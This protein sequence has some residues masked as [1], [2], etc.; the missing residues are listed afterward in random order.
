MN[1]QDELSLSEQSPSPQPRTRV[2]AAV[3]QMVPHDSPKRTARGH[4]SPANYIMVSPERP[5]QHQVLPPAPRAAFIVNSVAIASLQTHNMF[6]NTNQQ[7]RQ[8]LKKFIEACS[9]LIQKWATW[10]LRYLQQQYYHYTEHNKE[11]HEQLEDVTGWVNPATNL[12]VRQLEALKD[13]FDNFNQIQ[14]RQNDA[15]YQTLKP[16]LPAL[17]IQLFDKTK[18]LLINASNQIELFH[19]WKDQLTEYNHCLRAEHGY[20]FTQ[21][22]QTIPNN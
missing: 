4:N 21:L 1:T 19:R 20:K 12:L 3:E 9:A 10:K 11:N 15:T 6:I 2:R 14:L 5:R 8:N 13:D 17:S 18:A 22:L 16:Q 7:Q